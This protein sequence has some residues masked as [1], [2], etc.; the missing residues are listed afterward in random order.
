MILAFASISIGAVFLISSLNAFSTYRS[1]RTNLHQTLAKSAET[2]AL[3]VDSYICSIV[4]AFNAGIII[5]GTTVFSGKAHERRQAL[6]KILATHNGL[7]D[8]WAVGK[9]G[10]IQDRVSRFSIATNVSFDNLWTPVLTKKMKAGDVFFSEIEFTQSTKEPQIN[11]AIPVS[12]GGHLSGGM[13]VASMRLKYLWDVLSALPLKNSRNALAFSDAGQLVG[14]SNSALSFA[15]DLVPQTVLTTFF[16]DHSRLFQEY[17]DKDNRKLIGGFAKIE[18]LPF[19]VI[20]EAPLEEAFQAAF[21]GIVQTV[22]AALAVILVSVWAGIYLARNLARPLLNLSDAVEEISGAAIHTE[23][24]IAGTNETRKLGQVFNKMSLRLSSV[25][26]Q[27]ETEIELKKETEQ[28]LRESEDR[29]RTLIENALDIITILEADGTFKFVSPSVQAILGY[30]PEEL[31]GENAWEYIHPDDA[32]YTME[33]LRSATPFDG[34]AEILE[35]RYRHKDGSWHRLESVGRNLLNDSAVDGIVINS[36]DIT[37]RM[38]L[39]QKLH[40]SQKMEA[41]GQLT[42]GIAHDFNNI[43]GI[44]QGN[45]EILQDVTGSNE[46]AQTRIEKAQSGVDR[47]TDIT[48]KLLGYS[49]KESQDA[50]LT[51]VNDLVGNYEDLIAKSLTASIEVQLALALD[52]WEV[53]IDPGA[54]EDAILNLSLNAR[55]AMPQGGTLLLTTANEVVDAKYVA[56]NPEATV[57][58]YVRISVSDNGMGMVPEIRARILEPFFTTKEQ[59]KGTGLGLSMVYGFVQRSGGHIRISTEIDKGTDFHMY[60][61]RAKKISST[62]HNQQQ[63]KTT[64]PKGRETILVVDDESSLRDIAVSYLNDLGYQT[65]PAENGQQALDI[66]HGTTPIDAIF[67]DV[68]MPGGLD[69][70]QLAL[71]AHEEFPA[72]KT[73]L[74]SGFAKSGVAFDCQSD[75]KIYLDKLNQK[76][77]SKPYNKSQLAQTLRK[78]LDNKDR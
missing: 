39:E 41:V 12:R 25:I 29:F 8:V 32:D 58:D 33:K 43:L 14:H 56:K 30:K 31:V 67:S 44:I 27:L 63:V 73:L 18:G 42:S 57:G 55:D 2:A 68:V 70:Y 48:R 50:N 71:K 46:M 24:D 7:R 17:Q 21:D 16:S 72:I 54:F 53:S 28:V 1:A 19:G 9:D 47:G 65:V 51:N 40:R 49:R 11:V 37:D 34:Q 36:R 15:K 78:L 38:A 74:T 13:V 69:G 22:L 5:Q 66:L 23:V 10:E 3:R 4:S 26:A 6:N 35:A 77:L 60:L 75:E 59:S 76:L 62:D 64:L 52:L 45:L 61:P 20:V